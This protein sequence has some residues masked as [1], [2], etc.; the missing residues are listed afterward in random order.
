MGSGEDYRR[1]AAECLRLA[2]QIS[3]PKEKAVLA[4]M[5]SAWIRLADFVASAM[6]EGGGPSEWKEGA[7]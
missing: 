2:K 3:D 4:S 6:T 5:A 7:E 1:F